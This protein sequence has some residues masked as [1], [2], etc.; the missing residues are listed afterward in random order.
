MMNEKGFRVRGG[1][2]GRA[3]RDRGS[4]DVVN[5]TGTGGGGAGGAGRERGNPLYRG[6]PPEV[7]R[8]MLEYLEAEHGLVPP[9]RL[10]LVVGARPGHD[11]ALDTVN[12][13]VVREGGVVHLDPRFVESRRYRKYLAGV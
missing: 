13:G 7:F 1:T 4:F 6:D 9:V 12:F 11:A 10:E 5:E 2:P 8:K 3:G